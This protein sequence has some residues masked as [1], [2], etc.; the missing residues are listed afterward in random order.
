MAEGPLSDL[1][2]VEYSH[3]VQG[4]MCARAMADM[5]AD[6]VKV[7]PPEGDPTRRRGPFPQD[8][9]D[10][11]ASGQFLYLNANKRGVTLDLRS[12]DGY[13]R[14]MRLLRGADV[15]V[16]DLSLHRSGDLA[17]DYPR[18]K[19]LNPGLVVTHV[20]PF[21]MTGPYR[22]YKGSDLIAFHMG[23]LG[24]DTPSGP[25]TTSKGTLPCGAED[26]RPTIWRDGPPP[27]L[28]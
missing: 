21:G 3:G 13:D 28:P 10:I 6:V 11:E 7:E 2:V 25:S 22:E 19:E 1:R 8:V 23:G 26:T 27:P 24:Y 9:P 14:L 17:L 12:R 16:T 18:L 5:G 20:T 4:A 15:F